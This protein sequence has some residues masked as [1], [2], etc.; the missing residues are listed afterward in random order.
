[1]L[2]GAFW[3]GLVFCEVALSGTGWCGVVW[4]VPVW[5][6]ARCCAELCY[7][8]LMFGW[9]CVAS[10]RAVWCDVMRQAARCACEVTRTHGTA[11]PKRTLHCTHCTSVCEQRCTPRVGLDTTA[12]PCRF[13][14]T[15]VRC[16]HKNRTALPPPHMR[17][18]AASPPLA[19]HASRPTVLSRVQPCAAHR[20]S[21][22]Q[23]YQYLGL[24]QVKKLNTNW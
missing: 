22:W 2:S 20:N 24:K 9:F 15:L 10:W 13:A 18:A 7:V 19:R 21:H 1:M 6:G 4:R 3:C 8:A 16:P 23:M 14:L 12:V 17:P 5:C 11:R